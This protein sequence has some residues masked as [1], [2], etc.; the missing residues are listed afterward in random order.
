[1]K[2]VEGKEFRCEGS[3]D[4]S[5][6]SFSAPLLALSAFLSLPECFRYLTI[7]I[8]PYCLDY[9]WIS[10]SLPSIHICCD[11][12]VF[13]MTTNDLGR[14]PLR[15]FIVSFPIYFQV[16]WATNPEEGCW[17]DT[18]WVGPSY[19]GG[20]NGYLVSFQKTTAAWR[21]RI[22]ICVLDT[23]YIAN[24]SLH[25]HNGRNLFD[26]NTHP[27][28]QLT[29]PCP[30]TW[31]SWS[32]LSSNFKSLADATFCLRINLG[33]YFCSQD[34]LSSLFPSNDYTASE[35]CLSLE[36]NIRNHDTF[37]GSLHMYNFY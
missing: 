35:I 13:K 10:R 34:L 37:L 29:N 20:S 23:H 12:I 32:V 25:S 31:R 19:G 14:L 3:E 1:M 6:I 28:P 26:R 7:V 33:N 30:N 9:Y 18:I 2:G 8:Q 11:I 15:V 16:Y 5:S 21:F 24:Y 17:W 27:W 4:A 36:S 22:D